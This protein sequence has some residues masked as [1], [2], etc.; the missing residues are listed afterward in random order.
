MPCSFSSH[1]TKASGKSSA[2]AS[3]ES[4]GIANG[5]DDIGIVVVGN[6]DGANAE[7]PHL[8]VEREPLLEAN[9]QIQIVREA[10]LAWRAH[11]LLLFIQV[12]ERET[13]PVFQP[14][15][16]E[17]APKRNRSLSPGNQSVRGIPQEWSRGLG[18]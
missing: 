17:Q 5:V 16:Q 2:L 9:I 8:S 4:E 6:I 14:I 11:K 3:R 7:S 10:K 18:L 13:R 12:I 1:Q 15:S